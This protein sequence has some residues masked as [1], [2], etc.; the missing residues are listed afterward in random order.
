MKL[1]IVNDVIYSL[2]QKQCLTVAENLDFKAE[3]VVIGFGLGCLPDIL[4]IRR[5]FD[6]NSIAL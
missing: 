4:V 6:G 2:F 5:L 3:A 1:C